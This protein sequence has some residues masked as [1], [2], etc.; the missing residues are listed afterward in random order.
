MAKNALL[1]G[2]GKPNRADFSQAQFRIQ[3]SEHSSVAEWKSL[4]RAGLFDSFL[5][6]KTSSVC[7]FYS[8]SWGQ[9]QCWCKEKGINL[10]KQDGS[11]IG[12]DAD[13]V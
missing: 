12:M 8:I 11:P 10:R 4:K 5:V 7:M 1:F 9:L 3:S 6:V 2:P 13:Y